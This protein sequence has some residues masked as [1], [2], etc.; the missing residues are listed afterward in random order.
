MKKIF[1]NYSISVFSVEGIVKKYK[2]DSKLKDKE[3]RSIVY[4]TLLKKSQE[5]R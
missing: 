3:A 5:R 2:K 4:E 1:Y